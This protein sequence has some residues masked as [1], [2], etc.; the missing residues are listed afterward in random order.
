MLYE[1]TDLELDIVSAAGKK[2]DNNG[3]V[4]MVKYQDNDN[5][6]IKIKQYAV[7]DDGYASNTAYVVVN[8]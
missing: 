3:H 6:S 1:L 4:K 7:A 5:V 2:A 8:T